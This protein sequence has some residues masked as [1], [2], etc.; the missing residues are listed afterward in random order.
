MTK[1]CNILSTHKP[2]EGAKFSIFKVYVIFTLNKCDMRNK[3]I[4]KFAL[5]ELNKKNLKCNTTLSTHV[6]KL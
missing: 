1:L 5:F 3:P 2:F 4:R 6:L